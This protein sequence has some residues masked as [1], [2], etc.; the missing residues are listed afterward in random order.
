MK[1]KEEFITKN[2][3]NRLHGLNKAVVALTGGIATGKS[4]VSDILKDM[5]LPVVCADTLV[6]NIYATEEAKDFVFHHFPNCITD[7][8][9]NFSMLRQEVFSSELNKKVIENFIYSR[10]P[11]KF[12]EAAGKTHSNF[13]IYDVPLLFEK[14]LDKLVDYTICVATSSEIQRKRL[15]LRDGNTEEL[16][17]NI[18][19]SQLPIDE[20]V[21]RSDLVIMNNDGIEELNSVTQRAINNLLT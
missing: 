7:S 4:T 14:H 2:A 13:I 20:K 16:I 11:K 5:G 8:A 1:L 17:D 10:L 3:R 15:L 18:L 21:K 19:K 12:L 6:K 9:I